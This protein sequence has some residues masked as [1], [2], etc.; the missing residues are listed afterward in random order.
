MFV[1]G[2]RLVI[3]GARDLDRSL[4]DVLAGQ[5]HFTYF[6]VPLGDLRAEIDF[7]E[8]EEGVIRVEEADLTPFIDAS[9]PRLDLRPF[10]SASAHSWRLRNPE[11]ISSAL[12]GMT[13]RVTRAERRSRPIRGTTGACLLD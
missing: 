3:Y 7:C 1:L 4:R 5:M 10:H 9:V 13:T 8:L 11:S 6:P 2:N 12:H